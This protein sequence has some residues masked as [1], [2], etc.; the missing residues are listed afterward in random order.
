MVNVAP[1]LSHVADR[2]ARFFDYNA[3]RMVEIHDDVI[4]EFRKIGRVLAVGGVIRDL[5]FYGAKERPIS[6]IDFVVTGRPRKLELFANRLGAKPNRFGG[7]ALQRGGYRV[8]FWSLSNTW[9]R[10]NHHVMVNKPKDLTKTTFF[11]WDAIA[12]DVIENEIFAISNYIDRLN[13]RVLDINLEMTPSVKGNLVRSLRRLV[14]W[15][16]KPGR[17][18]S[19]FIKHNLRE[20]EWTD[21]I[22]A[23]RDAFHIRFLDQFNSASDFQMKVMYRS[24]KYTT[25]LDESRQISFKF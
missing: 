19:L 4:S 16:A 12:Y 10:V 7:F 11:D 20:F 23:E 3:P 24:T 5:A 25:G 1:S 18:L 14:M 15:D 2:A 9:A 21:L 22:L 8:D 6:D 17:K 13:R